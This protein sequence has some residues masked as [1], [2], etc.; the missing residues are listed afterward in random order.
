MALEWSEAGSKEWVRQNPS[1]I[2]LDQDRGVPE[3]PEADRTVSHRHYLERTRSAPRPGT[4]A[5]RSGPSSNVTSPPS[6][7]PALVSIRSSIV[8]S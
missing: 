1:A 4:W 6:A 2:D 7:A 5:S 3:E 8:S